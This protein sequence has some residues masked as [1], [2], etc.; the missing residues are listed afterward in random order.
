MGSIGIVAAV[1]ITTALAAWMA[2][3][4]RRPE[5]GGAAGELDGDVA[6]PVESWWTDEDEGEID[7]ENPVDESP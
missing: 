6:G 3:G 5:A 4:A 7:S 2:A 1:P